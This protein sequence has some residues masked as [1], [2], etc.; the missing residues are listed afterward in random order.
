MTLQPCH[1]AMDLLDL[2]RVTQ[3]QHHQNN[4]THH[5][6]LSTRPH[7]SIVTGARTINTH[8]N[9]I[10]LLHFATIQQPIE[11]VRRSGTRST[12]SAFYPVI[13][14]SSGYYNTL[15]NQKGGKM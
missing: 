4:I 1:K 6:I 13:F 2:V 10:L 3:Y 14:I 15:Q 8:S 9:I 12:Y 5:M 11:R 7:L